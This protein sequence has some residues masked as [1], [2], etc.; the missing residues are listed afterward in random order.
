M[1]AIVV[2]ILVGV[3]VPGAIGVVIARAWGYPAWIGSAAGALGGIGGWMLMAALPRRGIAPVPDPNEPARGRRLAAADRAAHL[4]YRVAAVVLVGFNL[5]W[6]ATTLAALLFPLGL[7]PILLAEP[8][9]PI[10]GFD[11]AFLVLL[12]VLWLLCVFTAAADRR[13]SRG[14]RT[15]WLAG[16]LVLAPIVP[17]VYLPWRRARLLGER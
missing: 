4:L 9:G 16:M 17:L 14:E 3:V 10:W 8:A 15:A 11:V 6:L 13:L 1:T 7:G 2:V 5:V 12:A